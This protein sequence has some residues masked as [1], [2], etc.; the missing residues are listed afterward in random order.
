MLLWR[1]PRTLLGTSR[2]HP[3][4]RVV[5]RRRGSHRESTPVAPRGC[6]RRTTRSSHAPVAFTPTVVANVVSVVVV[7]SPPASP[8]SCSTSSAASSV[9]GASAT[10]P[11]ALPSLCG[12]PLGLPLLPI[13]SF[14]GHEGVDLGLRKA[15]VSEVLASLVGGVFG[16]R[17]PLL[18]NKKESFRSNQKNRMHKGG[19]G[20]SRYNV[21]P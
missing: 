21:W 8:A 7:S 11:A 12:V 20:C 10:P 18:R 1:W 2:H 13:P 6:V 3:T 9:G 16:L 17:Q 19:V 4:D 5:R 15:L 14:L